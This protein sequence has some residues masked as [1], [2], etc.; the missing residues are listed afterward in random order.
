MKT[1]MWKRAGLAVLLSLSLVLVGMSGVSSAGAGAQLA[2][3]FLKKT[4]V[5]AVD[6][7]MSLKDAAKAQEEF[8]NVIS[9]EF[10]QPVGYKAGLTNPNVQKAFGLTE[11]VRGTLL[12]K[13][14]LPNGSVIPADFGAVPLF[15]GDLI[16]RVGDEAVNQA[17]TPEEALKTLDAVIPFLELPDGIFDAKVKPTAAAI[18]ANNVGARYGIMGEPIPLSATR[19][20]QERLKGFTL[21]ILDEK[22]AIIAEGKGTA[23][24]G[25]PLNA[26]IWLK[27]SLAAQGMKLKKGDLLSLGSL[28]RQ[29]PAKPGTAIKA[30]YVGL[31]PKGPVELS[32]SFK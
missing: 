18:V 5:S 25:D 26:V 1:G 32:V 12:K 11:P 7:Q 10:G 2:E 23:L 3:Q 30:K 27:S 29:M 14:L 6:Q 13:M 4:P 19:E 24:L 31:D 17:N 15:E 8:I 21:Q 9:K 20:W 28:T 16:V 22:G